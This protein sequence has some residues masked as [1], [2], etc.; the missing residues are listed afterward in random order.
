MAFAAA[1]TGYVDP[2]DPLDVLREIG[3]R[4]GWDSRD[5]MLLAKQSADDF[6]RMFEALRGDEV[7]QSI[8]TVYQ[9]ARTEQPDSAI[10]RATT[11]ALKRIA[12]KSP[13][14]ARK[15]AGLGIK[16]NKDE[17]QAT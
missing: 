2:R 4:R 13:L 9:L 16:L 15:I 8:K 6:E 7:R 14:R 3:E 11:E 12:A 5:V 10:E 17:D 1:R